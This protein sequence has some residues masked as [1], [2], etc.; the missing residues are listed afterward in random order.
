MLG[1]AFLSCPRETT[2]SPVKP[3]SKFYFVSHWEGRRPGLY[4]C[5]V[6]AGW[7]TFVSIVCNA[8]WWIR[9][10]KTKTAGPSLQVYTWSKGYLG[11]SLRCW[12]A[13]WTLWV[14]LWAPAFLPFSWWGE[15]GRPTVL[16]P[17]KI[18]GLLP[19]QYVLCHIVRGLGKVLLVYLSLPL[20]VIPHV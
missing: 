9:L 6:P 1:V 8:I 4:V 16:I 20:R 13:G 17:W 11:L 15:G 18:T 10:I 19:W 14:G 12:A 3:A 5:A 2:E 7:I